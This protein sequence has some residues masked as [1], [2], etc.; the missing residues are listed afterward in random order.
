[1]TAPGLR[2][3]YLIRHGETDWN[4]QRRFQGSTDIPLNENGRGQAAKL[5]SFFVG[6][7]IEAVLSSDLG[8]ALETAQILA[9]HFDLPVFVDHRLRECDGGE[10]EGASVA[11]LIASCGQQ[12]LDQWYAVSPAADE[13]C[14]PGGETKRTHR[15]RLFAALTQFVAETPHRRV[16]VATHGGSIRR[17]IHYLRPDLTATVVIPNC[18]IYQLAY[19]EGSGQWTTDAKP[20]GPHAPT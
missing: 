18:V 1:M 4:V 20:L 14:F 9:T 12:G 7:P 5:S 8:R 16:A 3:F 6:H 10:I 11:E 17:I 2:Y 13:F 15:E 19:D